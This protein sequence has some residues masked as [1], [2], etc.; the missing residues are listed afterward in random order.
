M[1]TILKIKKTHEELEE[2]KLAN[3]KAEEE[4]VDKLKN[5]SLE[6]YKPLTIELEKHGY[7]A[8]P[9]PSYTASISYIKKNWNEG[10]HITGR[11]VSKKHKANH[12]ID[13]L[14]KEILTSL[15]LD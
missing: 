10:I 4:L 6:V 12:T 5:L 3:E 13:N 9:N 8:F 15:E 7:T 2:L 14:I 1:K 11:M